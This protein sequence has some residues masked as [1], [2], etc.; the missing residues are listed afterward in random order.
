MA[1]N[2]EGYFN[3]LRSYLNTGHYEI[4]CAPDGN[5]AMKEKIF[6]PGNQQKDLEVKLTV[7]GKA[8]VIKLDVKTDKKGNHSD[9]L[10]HFLDDNGKP[11]SKRCDFVVF[12]LHRGSI[13]VL[14]FEFKWETLPVER[15]IAQLNASE[16]WCRSLHSIIEHYTTKKRR[17][18]L[19]KYV[20]S[21]HPDPS[22]YLDDDHYLQRDHSIRHYHYSEINGLS[23]DAVENTNVERIG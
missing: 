17:L 16:S 13:C 2:A 14:C 4:K 18:N 22:P 6:L 11:W 19:T 5:V 20:L 23:L 21:A 9:P 3:A 12:H 1:I 10:F 8:L 15:V 7:P